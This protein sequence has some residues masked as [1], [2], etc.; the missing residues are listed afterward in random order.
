MLVIPWRC[1]N[2]SFWPHKKTLRLAVRIYCPVVLLLLLLL[3]YRKPLFTALL[4]PIGRSIVCSSRPLFVF[5]SLPSTLT[6]WCNLK[7]LWGC[8]VFWFLSSCC[9]FLNVVTFFADVPFCLCA[10]FQ[11]ALYII[12]LPGKRKKVRREGSWMLMRRVK[13]PWKE[14][15]LRPPGPRVVL[16]AGQRSGHSLRHLFA[17]CCWSCWLDGC[18]GVCW[19]GGGG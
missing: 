5:S 9:F 3:L 13:P 8:V 11:S 14:L 4:T 12:Y 16:A 1:H 15:A 2:L 19:G 7:M 10:L 6:F 18:D 17:R